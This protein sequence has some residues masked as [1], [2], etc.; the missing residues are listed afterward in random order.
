MLIK[1]GG[2]LLRV[3]TW[4]TAFATVVGGWGAYADPSRFWPV[5]IMTLI[6]QYVLLINILLLILWSIR[7]RK[8]LLV[9]LMAIVLVSVRIPLVYHAFRGI[10]SLPDDHGTIRIMSF[11]VRLF[12]FYNWTKNH[13]TRKEILS[14]LR[15]HPQDIY[16]FQE[17]FTSKR[18]DYDNIKPMMAMPGIGY[19]HHHYTIKKLY[20]TDDFGLAT[21]SRY[22]I[23]NRGM[24]DLQT[25]SKSTNQCIYS[26]LLV[27]SDT[28][29]VY[30]FHLQSIR[31][32]E[33]QYDLLE[34]NNA[35]KITT[36]Q[37]LLRSATIITRLRKGWQRR[38]QQSR[39]IAAHVQQSPHPVILAGD[40]NDNPLSNAYL[41]LSKGLKDA[42][43]ESGRGFGFTY[44]GPIPGLRI[45]ALFHS[46]ELESSDFSIYY[47][48][49]SDHYPQSA[50]FRLK[51]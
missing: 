51:K 29:R 18:M 20:G 38:A 35:E 28:L 42:F 47:R 44:A 17:F 13:Q 27:G 3:V 49:Y 25:G 14:F 4:T 12:D 7:K 6:F 33:V 37:K 24:V 16:C 1:S 48:K 15:E 45:D 10:E 5:A 39:L 32:D 2:F 9:P 23:V 22:P 34:G 8:M 40:L 11:N 30:N 46:P 43:L 50:R 41:T 31:L 21:F 36:K 19:N 26:D